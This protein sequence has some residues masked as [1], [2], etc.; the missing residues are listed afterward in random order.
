MAILGQGS[1]P[2]RSNSI[3][4]FS[5]VCEDTSGFK[6]VGAAEDRGVEGLTTKRFFQQSCSQEKVTWCER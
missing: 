2:D 5:L 3:L 1:S 4:E 6:C